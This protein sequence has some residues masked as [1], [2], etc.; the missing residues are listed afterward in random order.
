VKLEVAGRFDADDGDVLTGW[1]LAG[2]GI[3]NR[4][5]FDV[6]A[7]LARGA[8]VE[9]LP[10]T[11]PVPSTF[12]CLYPHRRLQDPKVRLFVD[13]MVPRCRQA[14]QRAPAAEPAAEPAATA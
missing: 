13:F 2:R 3:A 6:A 8:L 14:V 7:H 4:P 10:A 12:G 11:P 1:A 9:V 5:R